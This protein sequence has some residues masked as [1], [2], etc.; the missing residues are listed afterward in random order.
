MVVNIL[1]TMAKA[2]LGQFCN[3][4]CIYLCPHS[5]SSSSS[6]LNIVVWLVRLCLMCESSLVLLL[7]FPLA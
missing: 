7:L 5:T 2:L 3:S 6:N 4:N 1:P